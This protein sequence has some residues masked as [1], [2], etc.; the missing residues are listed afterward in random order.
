MQPHHHP[1]SFSVFPLSPL[2]IA[3]DI[4]SGSTSDANVCAVARLQVGNDP[5]TAMTV[6]PPIN[7][8]CQCVFLSACVCMCVLISG[9]H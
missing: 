9:L 3:Y 2:H 8:T 1:L 5:L 7:Q 6:T 4:R